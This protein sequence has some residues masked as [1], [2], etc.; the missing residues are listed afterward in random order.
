M[1][2]LRLGALCWNQY[3]DWP[4]LLAAGVRAEELGYES[5]WTWDHLY[6][7]VGSSEGPIHEGWLTLAA[8]AQ[9]TKRIR[10]GLMVGANT[11]REPALTAKMA[12][13]LD[14]IS[15]GRATLGIGGAW[16]EEEHEAFG[17]PFGEGF[18]E[19]LR[20]LA[21]ALPIMRG[22]LRNE[23]PTAKGIHYHAK[24]VRND[25]PPIQQRLPLLIGG[26]GEQVTLKLVAK[27]GDAN[28]LGGGIEK[29]RHKEEVLLRHCEAVGRD[30]SEI[31]RTS[32]LGVVVIRD[33]RAEARTVAEQI[34]A[35][36]GKAEA[37]KGQPVGTPE[38]VAA[39]IAP[40][41][42]IGYHHLIAG[43][44]NPYDEES[45]TRLATEVRT[46]VG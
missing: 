17:L 10:I 29:I 43:F 26:G 34:F 18:P 1:P 15:G 41:L 7:I 4:S 37:W 11:F 14:H 12:T 39:F 9:A 24:A 44:P 38:D 25:P 16:F 13:T 42:E 22:M 19:R 2:D 30:P 23:R 27:Y 5:L 20:W 28:N 40:Y 6:P 35:Q 46:A 45:M 3:T 32:G 36:N 8:W 31:E 33:S 21:E